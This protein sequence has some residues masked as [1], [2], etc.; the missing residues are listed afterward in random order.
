MVVQVQKCLAA[1]EIECR[2][3]S[4]QP[5]CGAPT[6][7][8][9]HVSN[10]RTGVGGRCRHAGTRPTP[11]E[12]PC[13]SAPMVRASHSSTLPREP[14]TLLRCTSSPFSTCTPLQQIRRHTFERFFGL[15]RLPSHSFIP[16]LTFK[17]PH[18]Y[19]KYH[20]RSLASLQGESNFQ[21]DPS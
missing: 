12:H 13:P 14:H 15:A 2:L 4:L 6:V 17:R 19:T 11:S 8:R 3:A 9:G 10:I 20:A 18:K 16:S 1:N 5:S 21:E 7:G